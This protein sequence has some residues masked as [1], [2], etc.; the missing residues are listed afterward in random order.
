MHLEQA[1]VR[2]VRPTTQPGT[3]VLEIELSGGLLVCVLAD[4]SGQATAEGQPLRLRPL[5]H[6]QMAELFT[7]VERLDSRTQRPAPLAAARP[8]APRPVP[9]PAPRQAPLPQAVVAAPRSAPPL[10]PPDLYAM[11]DGPLEDDDDAPT[12]FHRPS[13]GIKAGPATSSSSPAA[14]SSGPPSSGLVGRTLAGKYAIESSIG[15]G[16]SG[17]VFRAEHVDLKRPVAVKV[18][19]QENQDDPRFVK[20]F[21]IEARTLSKLEH[22]NIARVLDFGE[23]PGGLLYF[24][25]ELLAGKSLEALIRASGTLPLRQ[26]LDVGIQTCSALAFAHDK[27][28][29]HRDVKPDNIVL[30]PHDDDDG[31][32][33]D[34]VKV[35][36]FGFAKLCDPDP[37]SRDLTMGGSVCGS[38]SYS[39]PEQL[40]GEAL[41]A[42]TDIYALAVT[43]YEAL[44]GAFPHE[45]GGLTELLVKKLMTEPTPI[46]ERLPNIDRA[47][48]STL[49][50]ALSKER[51]ARQSDARVFRQELREIL[52]KQR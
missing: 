25:M 34:L 13:S 35:C 4:P 26:V 23:E 10:P 47:L 36:D 19:H 41:D 48:E 37:D 40:M 2:L 15:R 50:R 17:E 1:V 27:G 49:M 3:H 11:L 5:D 44:T 43:L 33:C 46:R 22:Q 14:P 45:G 9:R 21:K 51:A 30:V 29:I 8:S 28:V 20:R 52:S 12:L 31:K 42:R 7:L 24:V 39:S 6:G 38:P 16:L 32:P 18:L